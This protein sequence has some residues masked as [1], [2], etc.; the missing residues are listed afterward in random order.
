MNTQPFKVS[1]LIHDLRI[2]LR[3]VSLLKRY[4]DN[5]RRHSKKQIRQI[6]ESIKTFGFVNPVLVDENDVMIAGHGRVEA[7][8]LLNLNEVPTIRLEHL[9][10][11]ER[12]AYILA[13]NRLAELADWDNEILAIELQ[14]LLDFDLVF[15]ISVTGFETPKIDMLI[16]GQEPE[17]DSYDDQPDI[18]ENMPI[19]SVAGDL[20][21][22]GKHRIICGDCRDPNTIDV[23]MDGKHTQMVITD[24]PY[25]VPIDGHVSGLGKHRH[26]DFAMASGEMSPK[27]FI[28]FL[29]T[30]LSQLTRVSK[31]SALHY[32]WMDWR[33]ITE[34][35]T[36]C[37]NLYDSMINLC[38][39]VKSNG[40]MGS[41][42]R[43]QHELIFVYRVGKGSHIN[44]VELGQHGRYRT[45][46][47]QCPGLNAFGENRD[48]S[49]SFHPT[50]KPVQLVADAILDTTKRKDIV[51]DS[52]LGSGTTVLAAER[53]GRICHGVEI[54]P[55]Y[56]DLTIR[57]WQD[58]TG[59]SA[60]H[61]QSKQ[62]F[63]ELEKIKVQSV[64]EKE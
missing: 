19:V 17:H 53:T 37:K 15:D 31:D 5:A 41:F 16:Q 23:L 24:P 47:W 8:K 51:L 64:T 40:G 56:V 38:V 42:Y 35:Q 59:K 3:P 50:V 63:N 22:L 46:V 30:S 33:H 21:R 13:D 28:T 62:S 52:F 12:R 48:S 49:L 60:I 10:E 54:E 11:S 27:E 57:R 45:N 26:K 4:S 43:S 58:A 36:A 6:A 39:W 29:K 1:T 2:E 61:R 34:L 18:D 14:H 25:N 32:I 9:S 44:N 20:W 7:A 55:K